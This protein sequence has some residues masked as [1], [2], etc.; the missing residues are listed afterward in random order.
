MISIGVALL[1]LIGFLISFYFTMVYYRK[2]PSNY[3]LVPLFCR[4]DEQTCQTVLSTPEARVFGIP[5]FVLGL[6]Y[7]LLLVFL[8]FL[9]GLN[10]TFVGF[11]ILFWLSVFTV[12][13]GVYLSY[14]LVFKIKIRCVLCFVSHGINLLIAILLSLTKY[15]VV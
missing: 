5:N 8:A 7:Y 10:H 2:I 15:S 1:A 4:M 11:D 9:G 14:A 13:L 6:F 3:P 12:L